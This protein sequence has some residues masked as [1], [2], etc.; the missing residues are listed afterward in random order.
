MLG[1]MERGVQF[2]LG[3]LAGKILG[4]LV[5]TYPLLGLFFE[6]STLFGFVLGEFL[7]YLLAFNSYHFILALIGGLILV[8]WKSDDLF[9]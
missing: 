1:T 2:V 9:D 4:A 7:R 3:F 8:V 5:S 6:D